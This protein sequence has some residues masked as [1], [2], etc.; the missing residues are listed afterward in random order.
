[1]ADSG[2]LD[3]GIDLGLA[4]LVGLVGAIWRRFK[5]MEK[6]VMGLG[7]DVDTQYR[8]H[9]R[10]RKYVNSLWR[11]AHPNQPA[12]L[13]DDGAADNNSDRDVN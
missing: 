12:P 9:Q 13:S 4:L 6:Q 7:R 8:S 11:K 1:M 3:K 2:W 5:K 10:T